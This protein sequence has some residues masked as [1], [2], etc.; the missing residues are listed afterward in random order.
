MGLKSALFEMK[1]ALLNQKVGRSEQDFIRELE[2]K[3][4]LNAGTLIFYFNNLMMLSMNSSELANQSLDDSKKVNRKWTKTEVEFMFQYINERQ[5]EGALNITEILE[6]VAQL[7]TRGYQSVNYKYYSLMKAKNKKEVSN[8]NAYQFITISDNEVPVVS[9]EV[10]RDS[11]SEQQ[12]IQAKPSEDNDLLDILSGLITNV[13][14]LPGI[15]LNELLRSLYQL[16]NMALQNQ[17]AVQ[18][19]A[20]MKTEINLEKEAIREQLMKKEQQFIQEKKRNDEL[21]LEVAKLAKEI[22]AFNKLGDA[23]KIQQ[24]KSYNQR[25]NYIIDSFG[26]VLQVSS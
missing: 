7:L 10:I 13:Q 2:D 18:Q 17:D 23:A 6:E 8:Q 20:S 9:T 19:V 16:T 12:V 15:N 11:A 21:Q 5:E 1:E 25:L 4:Q 14:Q 26:V 24:L 22:T 3:N